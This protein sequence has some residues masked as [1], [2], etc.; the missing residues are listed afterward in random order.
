MTHLFEPIIYTINRIMSSRGVV[1]D[2]GD[3]VYGFF[4]PAFFILGVGEL[5][6]R[7]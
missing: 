2:L 4:C 3:E 5:P 6:I 1:A 7:E